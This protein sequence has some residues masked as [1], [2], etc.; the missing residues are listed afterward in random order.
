MQRLWIHH[1]LPAAFCAV[2][3]LAAALLF[4]AI[5]RT[6]AGTTWNG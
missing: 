5:P 6:P 3:V 4:A 2:P 1:V